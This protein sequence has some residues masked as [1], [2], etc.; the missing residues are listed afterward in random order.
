MGAPPPVEPL[1]GVRVLVVDDDPVVAQLLAAL[2]TGAGADVRSVTSGQ[3]ALAA[4][5]SDPPDVLVSDL[6]MPGL[7]G[8]ALVR[9]IRE[10]PRDAGGALPAVAVTAHM[11]FET[12]RDALEAGYQDVLPKPFGREHLIRIVLALASGPEPSP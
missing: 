10:R 8:F 9:T 3:E 2:L 6:Y 7:D 4:I 12:R 1:R 11:S 5:G